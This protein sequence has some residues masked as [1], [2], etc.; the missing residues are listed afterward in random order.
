MD[1]CKLAR[2][3]FLRSGC[4]PFAPLQVLELLK[5]TQTVASQW[6]AH[7]T[8][9]GM[10]VSDQG[11]RNKYIERLYPGKFTSGNQFNMAKAALGTLRRMECFDAYQTAMGVLCHFPS[12]KNDTAVVGL[13]SLT[14][15]FEEKLRFTLAVP[16][17]RTTFIEFLKFMIPKPPSASDTSAGDTVKSTSQS[18]LDTFTCA[19]VVPQLLATADQITEL[20][21]HQP[22]IHRI[23]PSNTPPPFEACMIFALRSR[24]GPTS[25]QAAAWKLV[26]VWWWLTYLPGTA[27]AWEVN[28]GR[29]WAAIG[30]IHTSNRQTDRQ[31]GE[32]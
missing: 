22:S 31:T 7:A 18:L 9:N 27:T 3:S 24:Q 8:A 1:I 30:K 26:V 28:R 6:K 29:E 25:K 16:V 13:H 17:M 23:D 2:S 4:H 21:G 5:L 11:Q 20:R 19:R 10:E 12:L 32:S 14:V 15:L